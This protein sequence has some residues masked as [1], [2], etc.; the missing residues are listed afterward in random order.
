M[1]MDVNV[2]VTRCPLALLTNF[3]ITRVSEYSL[4]LVITKCPPNVAPQIRINSCIHP[5]LKIT[6]TFTLTCTLLLEIHVDGKDI[7]L[8]DT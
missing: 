4:T 2:S 3:N 1:Q 8:K 7:D 5:N 6:I